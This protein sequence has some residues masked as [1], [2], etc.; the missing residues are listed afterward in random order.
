VQRED[1]QFV[2]NVR[3]IGLLVAIA[4]TFMGGHGFSRAATTPIRF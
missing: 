3:H 4:T 2:V 1:L